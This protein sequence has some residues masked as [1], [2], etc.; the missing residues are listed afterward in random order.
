MSSRRRRD[1][2]GCSG[3]GCRGAANAPGQGCIL[4][5]MSSKAVLKGAQV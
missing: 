4:L 3:G 5:G 2:G 1:G